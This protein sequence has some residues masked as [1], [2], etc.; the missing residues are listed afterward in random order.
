MKLVTTIVGFATDTVTMPAIV[1]AGCD[2][3][4]QPEICREKILPRLKGGSIIVMYFPTR[5]FEVEAKFVL[6]S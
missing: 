4:V 5:R 3:E 6:F 2:I 1:A